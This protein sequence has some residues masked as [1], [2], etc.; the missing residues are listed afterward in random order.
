MP[1]SLH[2]FCAR[3]RLAVNA[4]GHGETFNAKVII[5][6][7][8]GGI[9]AFIAYLFLST[10]APETSEG[11]NGAG[12]ALSKSA[13]GYSGL[14]KL[15][16]ALGRAPALVRDEADLNTDGLLI[17][18]PEIGQNPDALAKLVAARL[19]KPTLI[20][21]PKHETSRRP[22]H[23]GW[24]DDA[25]FY[26]PQD[27]AKMMS[28]ISPMGINRMRATA[29]ATFGGQVPVVI[30]NN[31]SNVQYISGSY[32][33]PIFTDDL[34]PNDLRKNHFIIGRAP[35]NVFILADPD[36][37]NNIGM[38][39][40]HRAYGAVR[41]LEQLTPKGQAI[42]FDLTLNG[43]KQGRGLLDLILR[44]PFLA[45]TVA[46]L[47]AALM[48]LLNGLVRFGPALAEARAIPRGKGALVAN[49]ADLL[50]LAKVE[51]ELGGRYAALIRDLAGSQY[52]LPL[53]T[54]AEAATARFDAMSKSRPKFSNLAY[55]AEHA[56]DRAA[57]LEAAQQLDQ[58]RRSKT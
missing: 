34:Y 41:L 6:L 15:E 56:G 58:W 9:L 26:A 28:K 24:V 39:D 13:I 46:L 16:T 55:M 45:L 2:E 33:E 57:L 14:V 38:A 17:L 53:H 32:L 21:L 4:D 47:V 36:V 8:G 35:N 11:N 10:Y 44:P 22:L 27:I 12:H 20:V 37:L 25:G 29:S 30:F 42:T 50:K 43:F 49:T 3:W 5:W 51:H 31:T 19:G 48:A 1:R 18:T 54:S 52:G 40:P 23:S 7:I